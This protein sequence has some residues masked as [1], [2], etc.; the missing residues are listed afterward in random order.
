MQQ[1]TTGLPDAVVDALDRAARKLG[2]RRADVI[3][4]AVE[5]YLE[6]FDDFSVASERLR[7]GSDPVLEWEKVRRELFDTD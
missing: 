3:R 5:Q 6:D 7:N 1:I 4:L 2:L